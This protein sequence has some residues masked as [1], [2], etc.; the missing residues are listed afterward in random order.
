VQRPYTKQRV[1]L[2][3]RPECTQSRPGAPACIRE[4]AIR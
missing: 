3:K 4:C 2:R 1:N